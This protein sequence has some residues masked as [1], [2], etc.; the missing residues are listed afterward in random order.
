MEK[1]GKVKGDFLFGIVLRYGEYFFSDLMFFVSKN[2]T[3]VLL[4][5]YFL[6]FFIVGNAVADDKKLF[7][8]WCVFM[9]NSNMYSSENSHVLYAEK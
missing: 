9:D 3:V 1:M 4:I 2:D 8:G 6:V 7:R 5:R